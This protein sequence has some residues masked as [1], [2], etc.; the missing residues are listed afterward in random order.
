MDTVGVGIIG[1][2]FAADFHCDGYQ[3]HPRAILSA[4]ASPNNAEGSITTSLLQTGQRFGTPSGVRDEIVL[5][6]S[7]IG[8]SVGHKM[9]VQKA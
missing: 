1:S 7:S 4:V 2:K 3:R 5:D 8:N 9:L 6:I